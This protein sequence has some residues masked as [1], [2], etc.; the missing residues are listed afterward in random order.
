MPSIQA[1]LKILA[2]LSYLTDR[3]RPIILTT[4]FLLNFFKLMTFQDLKTRKRGLF[5]TTWDK[6]DMK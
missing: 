1:E 2:A 4:F 6:G 3:G 5:S